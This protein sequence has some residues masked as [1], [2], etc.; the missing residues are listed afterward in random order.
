M[1]ALACRCGGGVAGTASLRGAE[2]LLTPPRP[3]CA[4]GR[5]GSE[6]TASSRLC[7]GLT[8]LAGGGAVR[9]MT[10]GPKRLA[11]DG[12]EAVPM[13]LGGPSWSR[14]EVSTVTEGPGWPITV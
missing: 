8:V 14:T 7:G 5:P 2:T 1:G 13:L 3:I 11:D 10:P 9:T 12:W 6:G 4:G